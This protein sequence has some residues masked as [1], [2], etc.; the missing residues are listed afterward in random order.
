MIIIHKNIDSPC[1]ISEININQLY[2]LK[3]VDAIQ[4]LLFLVTLDWK[5][6][7]KYNNIFIEIENKMQPKE[8]KC[9]RCS[10]VL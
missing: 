9:N 8:I 2:L 4:L 10:D 6:K 3:K 7:C 5:C 1:C